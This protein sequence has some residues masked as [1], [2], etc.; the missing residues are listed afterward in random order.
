MYFCFF[1]DLKAP[2]VGSLGKQ[3]TIQFTKAILRAAHTCAC[4]NTAAMRWRCRSL[5]GYEGG[6]LELV[7]HGKKSL[8]KGDHGK[9]SDES[10]SVV[11][12]CPCVAG[13]AHGRDKVRWSDL[14]THRHRTEKCVLKNLFFV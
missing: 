13:V 10:S 14:K 6:R 7:D 8:N 9:K 5:R 2:Y 11:H 3:S 1:I 4:L 12:V